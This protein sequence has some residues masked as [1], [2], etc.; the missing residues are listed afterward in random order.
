MPDGV[1]RLRNIKKGHICLLLPLPQMVN[2][3]VQ[4][5]GRMEATVP[6]AEST[7]KGIDGESWGEE[8]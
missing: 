5:E 4:Y 7:L 2:G 3:F 6:R 8:L 1:E